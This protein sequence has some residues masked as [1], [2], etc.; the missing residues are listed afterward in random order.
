MANKKLSTTE[1]DFDQ[2]KSNLKTFLQGQTQFQDYDFEGSG[3]SILLDVLAY[4]THYNALYTNL[5][6]NESFLD[7]ASKRNSVVSIAK[8]LGY[9]P[10]SAT[11]ATA[12]IDIVVANPATTPDTL[13]IPK[14]T[15]FVTTIDGTSYNFY[16]VDDITAVYLSN[17]YTFTNV[18]IKEGSPLLFRYTVSPLQRFIIPNE[19]VDLSTLSVKVQENSTSSLYTPFNL[20]TNIVN[21]DNT[22][23]IYHVQEIDGGLYEVIFG[24]GVLGVSLDNGNVVH[25]N[26]MT[27]NGSGANSAKLFSYQG[28]SLLGGTV[29]VTTVSSAVGGDELEDIESIRY[30]APRAY[31][32]QNRGV[33]VEDYKSLILANHPATQSINVWGGEDNLPPVY[34]KVF[35]CIKPK[36][37]LTL[38]TDE[39]DAIK[40]DILDK[41]NVVSVIPEIVDPTY[42]YI[43]VNSN[44]YYNPRVTSKSAEDI[45]TLSIQTIQNY[46]T[47]YLE[48]FD[49]I[50]RSSKLTSALDSTEP[51]ITS[52]IT[53]I[54]LHSRVTPK[55]DT[56]AKYTINLT[57]PIYYSGVPEEAVLTTGFYVPNSD[58]LHYMD[59]DGVGHIRL[60]NYVGPTKNFV[61]TSIGEIDYT[62]GI[63]KISNLYITGLDPSN[64]FPELQFTFKPQSYDAVSIRNQLVTIP[65]DY[66]TVNVIIDSVASGNAAGGAN[67]VF[68]SSRS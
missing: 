36:N 35:L 30:N 40:R 34:G 31:S 62:N 4:N 11:A 17:K 61:N 9:T 10:Q 47:N 51:S 14:N 8:S 46:N 5:A 12:I 26:Y 56:Y 13:I 53:T 20:E 37:A 55:F 44:I 68:S 45:A 38:S 28:T 23:K 33:T 15:P 19:N 66:I 54:K 60:F 52:N 16:T 49:S 24:D 57:N 1:L 43:E 27:T 48:N 21:I 64:A 18:R 42:L 6:V 7:S 58:K 39:K 32:A 22:S 41:R 67:Y 59:D 3:L 65:S 25:L 29:S 50:F 2:I 63:V